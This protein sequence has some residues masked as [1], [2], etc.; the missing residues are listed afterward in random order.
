MK[1][2]II[3]FCF[4]LGSLTA[5]SQFTVTIDTTNTG[6]TV[7]V[8]FLGF[9][10]DQAYWTTYFTT[11]Q[12][13]TQQLF[14]NFYPYQQPDVRILANN[15]MYWENGSFSS[16]PSAWNMT[17]GTYT[18]TSCLGTTPSFSGNTQTS[19]LDN[20]KNFV[21]G[22][23]YKPTT[24]FGVSLAYLEPARAADF[25]SQVYNRFHGTGYNYFFEI[26][27]EPDLYYS[28]G[29]R[30]SS[31][32]ATESTNEFNLIKNAISSYGK[33]AGPTLAKANNTS[34]GSWSGQIGTFINNASPNVVTMHD[35][36]LGDNSNVATGSTAYLSKYLDNLH[37]NDEVTN[38]STGLAP[39]INTCISKN[40]PF[41]LAEANS[42]ASSGTPGVSDAFGSALWSIDFMFEL[43]KAGS[44]G[45]N[46]MNAS[47]SIYS[48]F[49]Y[50]PLTVNP[51]Y[52]GML[53]FARCVQNGAQLLNVSPQYNAS[54]NIK[55][56]ACKDANNIIR[57]L[58]INKGLTTT[59]ISSTNVTISI[60]AAN[61][62]AK[63]YD[64]VVSA[65]GSG[66]VGAL[67]QTVSSGA[68]FSIAGQSVSNTDGSLQG[69]L[70]Y[71]TLQP[72]NNSYTIS[73]P[74]AS[75]S[76]I[77]TQATNQFY[78]QTGDLSQSANWNT[79]SDGNGFAL[80]AAVSSA[81][82]SFHVAQTQS[83]STPL[84]ILNGNLLIENNA[85]LSL[86]TGGSITLGPVSQL[87]INTGSALNLSG[88]S[89]ILQSSAL[90]T[91]TV[92]MVQGNL[93]NASN[94]QVQRYIG[95][96]NSW[97]MIGFPFTPGTS[98]SA[99]SLAALYG[100]GYNAFTFTESADDGI[101]YGN[102]TSPNA[103]WL[104]FTGSA[105]INSSKG[106]LMV[107]GNPASVL[108]ASGTLNSGPQSIALTSSKNGWNFIAN[109]YA[110]HIDWTGIAARNSSLV[111]N[112]IY[113]YDPV[114][115]AYASFV[116]GFSTGNQ[117]NI[118]ENGAGFFV[119][120]KASGNLSIQESDKTVTAPG[121]SL[122]STGSQRNM[123]HMDGISG[124]DQMSIIKLALIKEGESIADEV[125][126]RWGIDPATDGFDGKYDAYDVG[127]R[128]GPDLSVL[129][130]DGTVYS[131]FHGAALQTKN[132]E[133]RE[134]SL[135]IG[136]ISEDRYTIHSSLLSAM[137]DDNEVY[138]LD[139]YTGQSTLISN[140]T[141]SYSFLVNSD[142]ASKAANRFSLAFNY[143]VKSDKNAGNILL[144]NN[145]SSKNMISLLSGSDYQKLNWVIT[146]NSGKVIESGN[147]YA[148]VKG[149]VNN[150][151]LNQISPGL[152][153]I[154]LTGDGNVLP[155]LKWVKQ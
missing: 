46:I 114:S 108:S 80:S 102:S 18:C 30:L 35:Y 63:K 38:L 52:Y 140:N 136:N 34:S 113:R 72:T 54:P 17:P 19:H 5:Q 2:V 109:P 83:L 69:T 88:N 117:S 81:P 29:R 116:N 76:Y 26:G 41:R 135:G 118:I 125:V 94:V 153:L 82:V 120:A 57:V 103:G 99:T 139:H 13:T 47:G 133:Q 21:S 7:P 142:I 49:T 110:A 89:M 6:T 71:T 98:I 151:M 97:R 90:G 84:N 43:A 50:G 127:R 20:Y 11:N 115:T 55:T 111:N 28:K 70:A 104:S 105:T 68:T 37:T 130:K 137:F 124:T 27:N 86:S 23:L 22:L 12:S 96:N 107:G 152:Y 53:M 145:P 101:N 95:S 44:A 121:V 65:S 45:I 155:T 24:L 154:R 25:A 147:F 106:I 131:I 39:S 112:A 91:A 51:V 59:D 58:V 85:T 16:A 67:G 92:N 31:Y 36:P 129:G 146:D 42:I 150:A 123:I 15:G 93:F 40:I 74:A 62:V 75:V 143:A 32:S 100:T 119:Q 138:L 4:L 144:L 61:A 122:M 33:I 128:E 1:R 79:R 56:W 64:L 78:A 87:T 141:A 8:N 73:M 66:I 10:F 132:K 149:T 77:E 14:N 126:L 48:P 134:V 9:S 3:I 60:P 148:V